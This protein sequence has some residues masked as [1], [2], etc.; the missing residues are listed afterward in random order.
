VDCGRGRK[1][2]TPRERD[3]GSSGWRGAVLG[4]DMGAVLGADMG[5]GPDRR[6]QRG[7]D[8]A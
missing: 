2:L 1:W 7:R 5:G 8:A 6:P 4:A 3:R